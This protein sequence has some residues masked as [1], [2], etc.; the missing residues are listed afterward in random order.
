MLGFFFAEKQVDHIYHFNDH[1]VIV[2]GSLLH[3][4]IGV[5]F[6]W[7]LLDLNVLVWCGYSAA[8]AFVILLLRVRDP[9][10]RESF[11]RPKR[12]FF[13]HSEVDALVLGLFHLVVLR[14]VV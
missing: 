4:T 5:S 1:A 3:W 2:I 9:M 10:T 14:Y 11:K 8:F 13:R 7:V 6:T 12:V